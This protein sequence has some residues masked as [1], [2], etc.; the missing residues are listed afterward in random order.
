MLSGQ[1][2]GKLVTS[3]IARVWILTDY[4]YGEQLDGTLAQVSTVCLR[5]CIQYY[6][7]VLVTMFVGMFCPPVLIYFCFHN[8]YIRYISGEIKTNCKR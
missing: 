6:F 5:V 1:Q 4:D 7:T 3:Y 2:P 8:I